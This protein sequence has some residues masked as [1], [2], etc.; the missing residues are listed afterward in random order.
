MSLATLALTLLML[1][2]AP[3][4]PCVRLLVRPQVMLSKGVIT[5]EVHL[6]DHPDHAVVMV[7]WTRD[8]IDDGRFFEEAPDMV[9]A[10]TLRDQPAGAYH[11]TAA[12]FDAQGLRRGIAEADIR[13]AEE[14]DR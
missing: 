8:G 3:P 13:T 12:V 2:P 11:F 10:R 6:A 9:V 7:T 4:A 1:G 5:V 14:P